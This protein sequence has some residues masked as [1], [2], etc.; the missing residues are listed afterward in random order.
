[1]ERF[2]NEKFPHL[3][4]WVEGRLP[5]EEARVMEERLAGV[6]GSV[7]ADLAWLRAF[8]WA[9]EQTVIESPPASVRGE[10]LR[11]FEAYAEGVRPP[12]L[13]RRLTATLA[14]DGGMQPA[15]GVRSARAREETAESQL[16]YTTEAA[17]VVVSVMPRPGGLFDLDGQVLPND[18]GAEIPPFAVQLL[19]A[20]GGTGVALTATDDLGEFAFESV[21]PGVYELLISSDEVEILILSVR[22]RS[23]TI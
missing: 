2:K 13:L 14:L 3:V 20:E 15:F 7:H 17:D 12:G 8:G 11:R 21:A 10:L 9:S 4:D 18:A 5:A 6:D 19:D 16:V 23:W 1:V 22:L